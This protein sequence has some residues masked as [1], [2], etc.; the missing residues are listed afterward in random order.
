MAK[1]TKPGTTPA[2][3][4]H[5][6]RALLPGSSGMRI[7]KTRRFHED[8]SDIKA[9]TGRPRRYDHEAIIAA[10][11]ELAWNGVPD[12]QAWFVDDVRELLQERR[13]RAPELTQ[14]K[15]VLRP[16]YNRIKFGR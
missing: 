1:R 8:N 16:I 10:A 5:F 4:T 13:I 15:K 7:P 11:E 9:P 2:G 6:G 12:R 3:Q 14:L